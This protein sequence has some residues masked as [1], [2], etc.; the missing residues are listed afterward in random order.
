MFIS[1]LVCT[2]AAGHGAA[3]FDPEAQILGEGKQVWPYYSVSISESNYHEQGIAWLIREGFI[4]FMLG[5]ME[6]VAR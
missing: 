6:G 5:F 3:A 4:N 1:K 2:V